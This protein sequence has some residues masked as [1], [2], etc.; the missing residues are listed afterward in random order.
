MSVASITPHLSRATPQGGFVS[1]KVIAWSESTRQSK[2][3]AWIGPNSRLVVQ[4]LDVSRMDTPPV[5][6]SEQVFRIGPMEQLTF[7]ITFNLTYDALHIHSQYSLCIAAKVVDT[8]FKEDEPLT[9][10]STTMNP[11]VTQGHPGDN[12]EVEVARVTECD[13]GSTIRSP[14]SL[15]GFIVAS[16]TAPVDQ[17]IRGVGP[18]SRILVRL[19]DVSLMD[20]P[21]VTVS[22]QIIVTGPGES[23]LFPIA[24]SLVYF[25]EGI[26]ERNTYSVSVRVEETGGVEEDMTWYSTSS[27]PVLTRGDPKNEIQV[28]VDFMS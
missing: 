9:W 2:R 18:N 25:K 26:H 6:L 3:D 27:H 16:E 1:G 21:S 19:S 8:S 17:A 4:L 15:S 10:T 13:A 5:A 12:I 22:E 24:F 11:V 20:V 14:S 28:D 23:R 7:P